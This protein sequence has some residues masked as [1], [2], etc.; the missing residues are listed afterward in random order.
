MGLQTLLQVVACCCV[1]L[2]VV[3][4]SLK[5]VKLL[6][7]QLPTFLLFRDR[8]NV[9]QKCWIHCWG[10]VRAKM[11]TEVLWVISFPRCTAGPNIVGSC[12]ICLDTTTNTDATTPSI[13]GPTMLRVVAQS[14]KP[15]KLLSH[16]LPK[17]LLFRDLRSVAQQSRSQHC[18]ELLHPFARS[19]IVST[20]INDQQQVLFVFLFSGLRCS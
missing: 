9:A 5:P 18:W 16:Q 3:T 6:I 10:H 8:R 1:L 7:H 2:R 17:F 15:V 13:V 20:V 4:Q 11:A 14:L 19:L 12:C